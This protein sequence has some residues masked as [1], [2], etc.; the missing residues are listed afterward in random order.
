MGTRIAEM[1]LPQLEN[2]LRGVKTL[3]NLLATDIGTFV[4]DPSGALQAAKDLADGIGIP[5]EF[6]GLNADEGTSGRLR[7]N[8]GG[9]TRMPPA[10]GGGGGRRGGGRSA[11]SAAR[12]AE[13]AR[14]VQ[15][16]ELVRAATEAARREQELYNDAIAEVRNVADA[17]LGSLID[18]LMEGKSAAESLNDALRDMLNSLASMAQ[19]QL[20]NGLFGTGGGVNGGG[21]LAGLFGGARPNTGTGN[22]FLARGGITNGPAIAGEDGTEAVVPLPDGR[23]IPVAMQ[24]GGGGGVQVVVNEAPGSRVA[25]RR[26]EGGPNMRRIVLDIVNDHLSSGGADGPMAGRY[27]AKPRKVR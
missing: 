26:E 8:L 23:R 2:L 10:R 16:L 6:G 3:Q 20:L 7:V 9:G 21:L 18:G 1:A 14:D 15:D 4:S 22:L 17:G 25:N 5:E 27:G 13:R 12:S 24:G 11:D 19:N